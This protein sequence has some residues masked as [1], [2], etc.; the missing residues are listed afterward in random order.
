MNQYQDLAFVLFYEEAGEADR[1]YF[2]FTQNYGKISLLAKG[3]RKVLSKLAGCLEP[4]A[5]VKVVWSIVH[6]PRLISAVEEELFPV[7]KK[8]PAALSLFLSLLKQVDEWTILNQAEPQLWLL[9]YNVLW[10]G[11]KNVA[12][13]PEII[14]FLRYYFP[15]QLLKITGFAPL[16][17]VC[18]VCGSSQSL[19]HFSWS[20]RGVVCSLHYQKGDIVLSKKQRKILQALFQLP[21]STFRKPATVKE[22][23]KEKIFLQLFFTKFTSL[24]KSDIM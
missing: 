13:N 21:L 7:I 18:A 10:W 23:L 5:L 24:I 22:I 8:N 14:E 16:L 2:L 17:D 11:E 6:Q 19:S 15:A 12:H 3:S 1:R 9:L 20:K 4:P